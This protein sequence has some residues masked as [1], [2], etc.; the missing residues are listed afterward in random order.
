MAAAVLAEAALVPAS[1]VLPVSE[2]ERLYQR[3]VMVGERLITHGITKAVTIEMTRQGVNPDNPKKMASGIVV[4]ANPF[5]LVAA[6]EE[7]ADSLDRKAKNGEDG[8]NFPTE[9]IIDA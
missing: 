9:G 1:C 7:F 3:A 6:L 2:I 8:P 5:L 4:K